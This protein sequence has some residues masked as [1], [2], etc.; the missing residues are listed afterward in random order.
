MA[1]GRDDTALEVAGK[2]AAEHPDDANVLTLLGRIHLTQEK[3]ADSIAAFDRAIRA[4][5]QH[6]AAR[7]FMAIALALLSAQ[8]ASGRSPR[9]N[10][11]AA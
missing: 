9:A 2:L 5:P 7:F 6:P 11:C 1:A 8:T 10:T 4:N 3:M